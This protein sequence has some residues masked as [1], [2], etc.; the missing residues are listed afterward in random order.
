MVG[1]D[2]ARR[3]R[4]GVP[5]E[6]D[7]RIVA[8]ERRRAGEVLIREVLTAPGDRQRCDVLDRHLRGRVVRE[9]VE[10]DF[11]RVRAG[12]Q[13]PICVVCR[14]RLIE[15]GVDD[16]DVIDVDAH[17]VVGRACE[18]VG[19]GGEGLRA[20]PAHGEPVSSHTAARRPVPETV[21]RRCGRGE[22]CGRAGA[23]RAVLR[24]R[25]RRRACQRQV[26]VVLPGPGAVCGSRI[27]S[28]RRPGYGQHQEC[29]RERDDA[30]PDRLQ[31]A[32]SV[33]RRRRPGQP[34][35]D[36]QSCIR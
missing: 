16:D 26:V 1:G 24:P 20:L 12:G 2:D 14:G 10:L 33:R 27:V 18:A 23:A 13:R 25:Q 4:A 7:P 3:W 9:V 34:S 5:V 21:E 15:P 11:H 30:E 17:P 32:N 19:A 36:A 31:E 8:R 28:A 35:H 29:Q 6:V 22:R